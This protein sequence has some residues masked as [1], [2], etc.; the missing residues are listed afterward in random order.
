[1]DFGRVYRYRGGR[2]WED[3]GQPGS[4]HRLNSMAT[5]KGKLYVCGFNIGKPPGHCYVYEGGQK[6]AV[7]G[8]ITN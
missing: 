8:S 3:L 4:N 1:M 2:Q 5:Y 6:W 7:K